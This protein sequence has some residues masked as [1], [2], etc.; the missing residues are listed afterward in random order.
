MSPEIGKPLKF[1]VDVFLDVVEMLIEADEVERA[2]WMLNNM[3]GYYRDHYPARA[4]DIR[5]RLAKALYTPS[6]YVGEYENCVLNAE[7]IAKVWPG[8]AQVLEQALRLANE[9]CEE[10]LITDF[11]AGSG[12]LPF[13][14]DHLGLKFDYQSYGLEKT[15]YERKEK[16]FATTSWFVAFEVIEHL[17]DEEELFDAY[18][19]FKEHDA[20]FLSTPLYTINGGDKEPWFT[21]TLG[22]LRTYTPK[23]LMDVAKR[24]WPEFNFLC[25]TDETIILVGSKG[26]PEDLLKK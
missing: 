2:R 3:P 15:L 24:F 25:V 23:E 8:R 20:V 9:R 11:G 21:R 4:R 12:W 6:D 5:D 7:Q 14:L 1:D 10:P 26:N 19:K 18:Q 17:R 16:G 13:Y 22:H